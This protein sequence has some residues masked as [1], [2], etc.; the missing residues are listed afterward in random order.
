MPAGSP[1]YPP[2][3]ARTVRPRQSRTQLAFRRTSSTASGCLAITASRTRVGVS[4]RA[5]PCSQFRSV[6]GGN[7]SFVAD[8]AW[9][10]PIL[11]RTSRTSTSGTWTSVTRTFAFSPR[12]Y[13][14]ACSSPSMMLAPT[15]DRFFGTRPA[16]SSLAAW[17]WSSCPSSPPTSSRDTPPPA[18]AAT[19]H[20][21]TLGLGEIHLFVLRISGQ[22]EERQPF[23]VVRHRA[24]FFRPTPSVLPNAS[25]FR[26]DPAGLWICSQERHQFLPLCFRHQRLR[27]TQE[28]VGRCGSR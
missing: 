19:F 8:C 17:S 12:V 7:P 28:F 2:E 23:A 4:G 24:Y 14:I 18:P 1:F 5:R 22:Q 13:A 26:D 9:L 25:G 3:G 27:L 21:V 16:V 6:A 20:A 15:V 11:V 10:S